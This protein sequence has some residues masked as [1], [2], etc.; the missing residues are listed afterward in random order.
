MENNFE[1]NEIP[2]I[3]EAVETQEPSKKSWKK[4]ALDWIASIAAAIIIALLIRNFVFTMVEV[5]GESMYPTLNDGDRLFTQII[6][7]NNPKQGDI[8]IFNPSLSEYDREPNKKIAYVKR[9][10]AVEGQTVELTPDGGVM[11]DGEVVTEDY[12]S[13]PIKTITPNGV[14]FP[15]VVPEDTVF[16]LGDNRSA[17]EDS[18][19]ADVGNVKRSEIYGK[20]WHLQSSRLVEKA[21]DKGSGDC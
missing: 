21:F 20:A 19:M 15:F 7:Y 2:E 1:N 5:E 18:R 4:E 12:I 3:N 6:A 17:S 16:V 14:E 10:I 8:I 11:V 13:E 9:V